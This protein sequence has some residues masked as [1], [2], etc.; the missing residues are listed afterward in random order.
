MSAYMFA[1]HIQLIRR[2]GHYLCS[3][4][5][6]HDQVLISARLKE[7]IEQERWEECS[8]EDL[9]EIRS[10]CELGMVVQLP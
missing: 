2:N 4:G 6:P 10:L 7:L 9:E 1:R 3:Q 8:P 5:Q